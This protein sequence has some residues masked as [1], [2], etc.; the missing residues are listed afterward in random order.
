MRL[1]RDG[2][3]DE[4][5]AEHVRVSTFV[6]E[7]MAVSKLLRQMQDA[8]VHQVIVIDEYGGTAGLATLEDVIEELVG[9]IVDEFDVEETPTEE[10]EGG[11]VVVNGKMAIDEVDDLLKAELPKGS[12][13]TIGGLLLDLIGGIPEVGESE[14]VDGYRLTAMSIDGRRID[15][16]RIDPIPGDDEGGNA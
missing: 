4:P 1:E 5:V 13:D 8:K 7:N 16:V 14:T 12:W 3:G 2:R 10:L 9:E 15:R 6:P 11:S